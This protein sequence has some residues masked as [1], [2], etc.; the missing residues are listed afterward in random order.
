VTFPWKQA[1]TLA[2]FLW[3]YCQWQRHATVTIYLP[4]PPWTVQQR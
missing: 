1:F 4:W 2:M 3:W